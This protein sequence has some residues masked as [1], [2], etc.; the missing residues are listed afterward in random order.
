MTAISCDSVISPSNLLQNTVTRKK[1]LVSPTK[2]STYRATTCY[3]VVFRSP[4]SAILHFCRTQF[5][6]IQSNSDTAA[7]IHPCILRSHSTNASCAPPTTGL[8]TDN[9]ITHYARPQRDTTHDKPRSARILTL[10]HRMSEHNTPT[11]KSVFIMGPK[12]KLLGL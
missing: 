9:D 3:T 10:L 1:L 2:Q 8:V 5:L 11:C 12:V 7:S 4:T 6:S